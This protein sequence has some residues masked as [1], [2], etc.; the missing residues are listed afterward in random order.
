[1]QLAAGHP[2][3]QRETITVVRMFLGVTSPPQRFIVVL[4]P[5]SR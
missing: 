5:P 4:A 1:M 3:A 2:G